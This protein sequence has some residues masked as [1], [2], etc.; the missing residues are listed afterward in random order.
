M[1]GGKGA[2]LSGEWYKR[3]LS[4]ALAC[5]VAS[6]PLDE[7]DGHS[8]GHGADN[9][10]FSGPGRARAGFAGSNNR[11][12]LGV[13]GMGLLKGR[14]AAGL[15]IDGREAGLAAQLVE[16]WFE[17]A[18]GSGGAYGQANGARWQ[19]GGVAAA[20]GFHDADGRTSAG[21]LLGYQRLGELFVDS[22]TTEREREDLIRLLFAVSSEA[23]GGVGSRRGG[24][25]KDISQIAQI[26]KSAYNAI[27]LEMV[28]VDQEAY[29]T[30]G[31][32]PNATDHEIRTVY[33]R[34]AGQFHPDT[35]GVL[36]EHQQA[37]SREAFMRIKNAFY[38]IMEERQGMRRD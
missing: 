8:N 16:R 32:S 10:S 35:G 20:T 2:L 21:F 13:A 4:I 11:R 12:D 1:S 38:R 23:G 25:I 19:T 15:G 3:T 6:E 17:L 18:G 28:A 34:L 30:L 37:E 5:T 14:I 29:D 7:P 33:R 36:E 22:R 27:R 31:V 26:S 24:L 9:S